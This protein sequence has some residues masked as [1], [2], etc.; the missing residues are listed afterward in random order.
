MLAAQRAQLAAAS[1]TDDIAKAGLLPQLN[2]GVERPVHSD[3]SARKNRTFMSLSQQLFNLPL[4]LNYE[5]ALW[6]VR[7]AE[8]IYLAQEQNLQLSM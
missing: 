5:S 6:T 8:S 7:V 4:K 3:F 2:M 1:E